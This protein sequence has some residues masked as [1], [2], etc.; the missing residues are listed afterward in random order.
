MDDQCSIAQAKNKLPS[1][2]HAVEKGFPVKL[3]R[4]G[5]PVAV[6]LSIKQYERLTLRKEGFWSA[7][8]AFHDLL[9]KEDIRIEQADFE[10]LR[11][12]SR[13]RDVELA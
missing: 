12:A 13:G 5:R 11:D 1:I 7:I 8:E 3:T 6:L 10:G 9:E 4:H 2:I